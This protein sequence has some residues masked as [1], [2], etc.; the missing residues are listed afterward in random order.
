MSGIHSSIQS[1]PCGQENLGVNKDRERRPQEYNI[2]NQKKFLLILQQLCTEA[3]IN[4]HSS[5]QH[6]GSDFVSAL[7]SSLCPVQC[8]C[9]S[10]KTHRPETRRM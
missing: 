7:L 4:S 1:W 5:A 2:I 9:V 10:D 6:W 8:V 3:Q